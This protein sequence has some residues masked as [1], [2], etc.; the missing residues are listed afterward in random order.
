MACLVNAN[1]EHHLTPRYLGGEDNP[2]NLVVISDVC[3]AMWHWSEWQRTRSPE[4]RGAYH[5]LVGQL[6][7]ESHSSKMKRLWKDPDTR[8]W[9]LDCRK[10]TVKRLHE[11]GHYSE[12]GKKGGKASAKS[13]VRKK[14]MKSPSYARIKCIERAPFLEPLLDRWLTFKHVNGCAL[15]VKFD[16]SIRP[17][18]QKLSLL[19]G[20]I[21]STALWKQLFLGSKTVAGWT[22]VSVSL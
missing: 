18:T 15:T 17:I 7:G 6:Q 9:M 2:E 13:E 10:D 22:F 4:H 3:H 19:S 5:L 21:C 20:K 11:G 8:A 1:H 12:L 14:A 16:Y